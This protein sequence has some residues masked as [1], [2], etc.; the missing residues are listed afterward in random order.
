[1]LPLKEKEARQTSLQS[2]KHSSLQALGVQLPLAILDW[3][4]NKLCTTLLLKQL[5]SLADLMTVDGSITSFALEP[6]I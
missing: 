6:H 3:L 2:I 5:I 4:G 1:M